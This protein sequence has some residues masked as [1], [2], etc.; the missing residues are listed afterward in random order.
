M[1]RRPEESHTRGEWAAQKSHPPKNWTESGQTPIRALLAAA[2]ARLEDA[3]TVT[4]TTSIEHVIIGVDPHKL[5]ATFEVVDA[6]ERLLGSG[7]FATNRAGCAAIRT[8]AKAGSGR[9]H[10]STRLSPGNQEGIAC[11]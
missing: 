1:G 3:E 10:S 6:H 4:A 8:Y 9:D 11:R 7:R 2:L 5:S